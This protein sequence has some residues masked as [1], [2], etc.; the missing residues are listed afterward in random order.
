[1]RRT[2][3]VAVPPF[4]AR[5]NGY[6]SLVCLESVVCNLHFCMNFPMHK[7]MSGLAID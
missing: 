3:A 4:V 7:S 1:M 5:S 2:A 6:N